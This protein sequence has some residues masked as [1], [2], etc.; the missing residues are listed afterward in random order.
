MN[1]LKIEIESNNKVDNSKQTTYSSDKE[2]FTALVTLCD[3]LGVDVPFWT[4]DEERIINK[5][6]YL[7]LNMDNGS[8]LRIYSFTE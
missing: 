5:K 8:V 1:R 2:F 3:E 4:T 6:G 7:E